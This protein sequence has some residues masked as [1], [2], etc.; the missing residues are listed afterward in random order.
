[1]KEVA[2]SGSADAQSTDGVHEVIDKTIREFIGD[3][4]TAS[5]NAALAGSL[6]RTENRSRYGQVEPRIFADDDGTL[7]AGLAGYHAI[8]KVRRK[9]LDALADL[10]AACE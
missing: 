10:I 6:E 1:M 7:A 8:V 4:D 3:E 5:R 9:L 2:S